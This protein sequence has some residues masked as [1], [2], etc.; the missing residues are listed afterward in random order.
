MNQKDSLFPPSIDELL[1]KNAGSQFFM[2]K[3]I[4]VALPNQGTS[5]SNMTNLV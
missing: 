1:E 5:S 2:L 4:M 3:I